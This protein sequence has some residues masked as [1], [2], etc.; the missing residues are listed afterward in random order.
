M[1][2]STRGGGESKRR[3]G[4]ETTDTSLSGGEQK[5]RDS[6]QHTT[7]L[8][9][10]KTNWKV[11]AGVNMQQLTQELRSNTTLLELDFSDC[12]IGPAGTTLLAKALEVNGALNSLNLRWNDIGPEGATA[13]SAAT[14]V[15]GAALNTLDLSW[16]FLN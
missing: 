13:L 1:S 5:R 6:A 9:G 3:T 4:D 10:G 11:R 8:I 16:N 15:N 14:E 12:N 2:T 7:G